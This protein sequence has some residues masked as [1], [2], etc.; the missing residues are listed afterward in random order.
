MPTKLD[1]V[2]SSQ[3]SEV[4]RPNFIIIGLAIRRDE[5]KTNR[6]VSNKEKV[7]LIFL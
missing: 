1:I 2:F 3:M 5:L 6:P 7:V 4:F